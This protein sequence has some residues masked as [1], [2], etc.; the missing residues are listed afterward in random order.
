MPNVWLGTF[1]PIPQGAETRRRGVGVSPLPP[2]ERA[3]LVQLVVAAR[4]AGA[5]PCPQTTQ[6]GTL[7]LTDTNGAF[8]G[9]VRNSYA[10]YGLF[11]VT[12]NSAEALKVSV[13]YDA[14]STNAPATV[15]MV[16]SPVLSSS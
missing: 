4:L 13:K 8:K 15:T 14:L 10:F 16:V 5:S 3:N 1:R 2:T 9:Y 6:T 11:T 7:A 12:Q